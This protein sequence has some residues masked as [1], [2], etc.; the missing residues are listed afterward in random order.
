M[1]LSWL[2]RQEWFYAGL[3][4]DTASNHAAILLFVLVAPVFT[5]FITP[6]GAWFSRRHEFQADAY[7]TQHADAS[8]L[9]TA[10][11]KLYREN[12]TTLTPDPVYSTFYHSHP[13]ALIR[14]GRLRQAKASG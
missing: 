2:A 5:F 3:G 6:I 11:V 13:P 14:I 4:V 7:A 10:L 1:L 12:A 8:A 9:A